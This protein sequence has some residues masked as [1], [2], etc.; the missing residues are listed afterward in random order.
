ME[1]RKHAVGAQ[2]RGGTE[3]WRRGGGVWSFGA[4]EVRCKRA[5]VEIWSSG[6]LEAR[7]RCADVEA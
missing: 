5:N 2:R 6:A 7:C 4:L 3:V 1:L